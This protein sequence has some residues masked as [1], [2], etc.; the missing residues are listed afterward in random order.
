MS[1]DDKKRTRVLE[2]ISELE[3]QLRTSLAKKDSRTPEIN[4]GAVTRRIQLLR[5]QL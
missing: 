3:E 4:V 1:K 5:E 2:R